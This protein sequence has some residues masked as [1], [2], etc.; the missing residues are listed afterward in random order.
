MPVRFDEPKYPSARR[1]S[2]R[3][4]RFSKLQ[5]LLFSIAALGVSAWLLFTS[6]LPKPPAPFTPGPNYPWDSRL[7]RGFTL[8]ELL[9]VIAIIA[10]LSSVVVSS[11]RSAQGKSRDATRQAE[12]H[13]IQ[14]AISL[15][16]NDH[17]GS[18]PSMAIACLG[19]GDGSTCWGDRVVPGSS[20]LVAALAPYMGAIPADPSPSR[21][22]GDH[23]VYLN[24]SVASYCDGSKTVTG[25]FIAYDPEVPPV[26]GG[27]A[28][29]VGYVACCPSGGYLCNNLGGYFCA[30]PF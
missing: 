12:V 9:V 3:N 20:A 11:L 16:A 7:P 1:T 25:Q 30:V 21:G 29:P 28:C 23:Y 4:A 6:I 17:S 5:L 26:G 10:L 24:G 8:I 15:Y 22:W 27:Y 2:K 19:V 14:N 18:F 13:Q